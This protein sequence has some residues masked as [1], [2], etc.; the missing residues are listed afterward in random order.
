MNNLKTANIRCEIVQ[1]DM[2]DT[3]IV[4][5][6]ISPDADFD[7]E[8]EVIKEWLKLRKEFTEKGILF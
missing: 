5:L 8:F 2:S 1:Q 7:K 3:L 6:K 4:I